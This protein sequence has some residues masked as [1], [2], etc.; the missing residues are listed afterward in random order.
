MP[1]TRSTLHVSVQW[2][3]YNKRLRFC[4]E[5]I[6]AGSC[7]HR[8]TP[9]SEQ[10]FALPLRRG[11][12][13]GVRPKDAWRVGVGLALPSSR[14]FYTPGVLGGENGMALP[15]ASLNRN[16]DGRSSTRKKPAPRRNEEP[17]TSLSLYASLQFCTPNRARAAGTSRFQS[18][19]NP[20]PR[21]TILPSLS[22]R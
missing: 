7:C 20:T 6:L 8:A 15:I 16:I 14:G 4:Q 13:G 17:F 2:Y 3:K 19:P 18:G 22:I 1:L 11:G 21:Q 5:G 9:F 10:R 12:Q